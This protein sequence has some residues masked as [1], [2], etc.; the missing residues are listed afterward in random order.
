MK[1]LLSVF[2]ALGVLAAVTALPAE[3]EEANLVKLLAK[4]EK[5]MAR[6]DDMSDNDVK[7]DNKKQFIDAI[8]QE[9][10]GPGDVEMMDASQQRYSHHVNVLVNYVNS[11]NAISR[12]IT[13]SLVPSLRRVCPRR[14]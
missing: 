2:I 9:D 3:N 6:Q 4:I 1:F 8:L 14:G 12:Y 7:T 13:S 5:E 11:L 10:E